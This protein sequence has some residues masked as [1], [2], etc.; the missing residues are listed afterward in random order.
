MFIHVIICLVGMALVY[1]LVDQNQI[2]RITNYSSSHS[3][4]V[5]QQHNEEQQQQDHCV[6]HVHG[7]HHSGTGF[8]R[9][10]IYDAL[11]GEAHASMHQKTHKAE[12]EGQHIQT[13]YPTFYQR[14]RKCGNTTHDV[15]KAVARRYYCPDLLEIAAT[16]TNAS[17]TLLEEWS[18]YWN[19]TKPYLIQKTPTLDVLFL[20]RMKT[21]QTVHAIVMR[22]PFLWRPNVRARN[23]AFLRLRIWLDIWAHTL[24]LLSEHQVEYFAVVQYEVTLP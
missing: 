23:T 4:L 11:G 13:V 12:D 5:Q 10:T 9:Q 22:H 3:Y 21:Y 18:R 15:S 16:Q 8:L 17:E 19:M 14:A 20:E 6:I 7:M 1:I 24:N 2:A